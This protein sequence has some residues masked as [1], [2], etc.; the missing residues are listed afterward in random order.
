MHRVRALEENNLQKEEIWDAVV[1]EATEKKRWKKK[2]PEAGRESHFIRK[3]AWVRSREP[4]GPVS[5]RERLWKQIWTECSSQYHPQ[6]AAR[7]EYNS[8]LK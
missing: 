7:E 8:G 2:R 4:L 6:K 3:N 5:H 1:V